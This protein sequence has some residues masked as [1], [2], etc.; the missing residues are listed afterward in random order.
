MT[1]AVDEIRILKLVWNDQNLK[2]FGKVSWVGNSSL[3]VTVGIDL[4]VE[5]GKTYEPVLRALFVM[6]ARNPETRGPA[7]VNRL[8]LTNA[9]PEEKKAFESGQS[10][11][12][13]KQNLG[14]I[15]KEFEKPKKPLSL[16]SF[17][18]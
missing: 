5:K 3:E 2:L 4:E 7:T 16:S 14:L 13:K 6:V 12:K 18:F 10:R 17:I 1:A 8:D 9:T 15:F 11:K